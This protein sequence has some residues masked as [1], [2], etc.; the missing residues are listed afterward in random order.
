ML[1][2]LA[3]LAG[4]G[5]R[6]RPQQAS[7]LAQP[8]PLAHAVEQLH[9]VEPLQVAQGPAGGGLGHGQT[10][11]GLTD[12]LVVRG[13]GEYLQLAQRELHIGISNYLYLY[14]AI[15]QYKGNG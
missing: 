6:R 8:H 12:I 10:G 9:V 3:A 13:G 11:R 4:L 7:K 1:I 14:Y 5:F 2:R 15:Y